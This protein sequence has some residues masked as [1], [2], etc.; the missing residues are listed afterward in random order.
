MLLALAIFLN[1]LSEVPTTRDPPE[2]VRSFA[3]PCVERVDSAAAFG[4][5]ASLRTG[6]FL[7]AFNLSDPANSSRVAPVSFEFRTSRFYPLDDDLKNMRRALTG[8]IRPS[9]HIGGEF[10]SY[11]K[12][13]F[14]GEAE[15][16]L[17][18]RWKNL[19]EQTASVRGNDWPV[20]LDK[21]RVRCAPEGNTCRLV[22][23]ARPDESLVVVAYF[24]PR[25]EE[26]EKTVKAIEAYIGDW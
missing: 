24:E 1:S 14:A 11:R 6:I 10:A 25:K 7:C 2:A 23:V 17:M 8:N 4:G 12:P 3:L 26:M 16:I 15:F 20:V 21:P 19:A 13:R 9:L 5:G 18:P 22:L